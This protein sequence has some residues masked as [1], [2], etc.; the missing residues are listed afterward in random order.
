[1][2]SARRSVTCPRSWT[3]EGGA[4]EFEISLDNAQGRQLGIDGRIINGRGLLITNVAVGGLLWAWNVAHPHS[5]VC[6]E[7]LITEVNGIRSDGRQLLE[8]IKR[9]QVLRC[10][11]ARGGTKAVGASSA[12]TALSATAA[13]AFG[14]STAAR[15]PTPPGRGASLQIGTHFF[16]ASQPLHI[17]PSSA[18][19]V[20]EP[21]LSESPAVKSAPVLASPSRA[22][23]GQPHASDRTSLRAASRS[24]SQ[25]GGSLS[26][27]RCFL[28]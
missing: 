1:V 27:R 24:S 4:K 5:L 6:P 28:I 20:S 12:T 9:R 18:T 25:R 10:T 17:T 3:A 13:L 16:A 2:T 23:P 15:S 7:D 22:H 26:R 14:T 21:V 11:I 19:H 8:E